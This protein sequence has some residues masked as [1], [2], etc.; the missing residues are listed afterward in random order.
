MPKMQLE[1]TIFDHGTRHYELI[2][3][4][5]SFRQLRSLSQDDAALRAHLAGSGRPWDMSADGTIVGIA[6]HEVDRFVAPI[7]E[8]IETAIRTYRR[9]LIVVIVS[10]VEAAISDAFTVLFAFHPETIKGLSKDPATDGFN[11]A[12]SIDQLMTATQL[13]ELRLAVV[14]RAV[15]YACQGKSKKT[16]LCR[17]E[18]LFADELDKLVESR[19]ISLV[20][21]RNRIVHDNSREDVSNADVEDSFDAAIAFVRELGQFV[22]NRSLPI[23]DPL[24]LYGG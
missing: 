18:R 19:F 9:Q 6:D 11:P 15:S 20:E 4:L 21:L 1:Q 8:S 13:D 5:G 24:H 23:H 17:L 7:A 14:E 3:A 22:S 12:V 16:V 10:V 2:E